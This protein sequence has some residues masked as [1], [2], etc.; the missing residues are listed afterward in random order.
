MS[1]LSVGDVLTIKCSVVILTSVYSSSPCSAVTCAHL[2]CNGYIVM[3]IHLSRYN[4][5]RKHQTPSH[6]EGVD[7]LSHEHMGIVMMFL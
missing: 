7:S 6:Y 1:Q 3:C 4:V 5:H 2:S